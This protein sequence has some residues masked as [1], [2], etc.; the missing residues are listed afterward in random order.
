M[1]GKTLAFLGVAPVLSGGLLQHMRQMAAGYGTCS[2]V[3]DEKSWE[4]MLEA[5]NSV[6]YLS[7]GTAA[8]SGGPDGTWKTDRN[9]EVSQRRRCVVS[10]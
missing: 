8:N 10:M 1:I 9:N 7:L 4:I 3:L 6:D 2:T 5:F